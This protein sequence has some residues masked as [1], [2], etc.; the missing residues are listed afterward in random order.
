MRVPACIANAIATQ[1]SPESLPAVRRMNRSTYPSGLAL[2]LDKAMTG[3]L[4]A[5]V[6]AKVVL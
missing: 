6:L 5:H 1:I 3:C 4:P 2:D